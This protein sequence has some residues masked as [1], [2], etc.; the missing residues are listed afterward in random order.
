MTIKQTQNIIP[1][2]T[3]KKTPTKSIK[4]TRSS[5]I[6]P[7]PEET[8]EPSL[9]LDNQSNKLLS[10]TFIETLVFS[11]SIFIIIFIFYFFLCHC[12]S[13]LKEKNGDHTSLLNSVFSDSPL[14]SSSGTVFSFVDI[15]SI[16]N[17]FKS[18]E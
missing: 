8:I 17:S 16:E 11:S 7:T 10:V 3:I 15:D 6:I 14:S 1:L 13:L 2:P 5:I 4:P 18:V 9:I 12:K